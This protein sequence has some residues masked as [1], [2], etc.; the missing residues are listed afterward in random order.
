MR[1]TIDIPENP[2]NGDVIEAIFPKG[3]V[4]FFA[5]FTRYILPNEMNEIYLNIDNGWWENPY[6][7]VPYDEED[8]RGGK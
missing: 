7:R 1:L 4:A 2:T 3:K 8:M 5:T 6:D